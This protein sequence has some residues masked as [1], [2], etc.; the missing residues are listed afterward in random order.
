MNGLNAKGGLVAPE[1]Y[2]IHRERLA[3]HGK[4]I[5][6]AVRGRIER[7]K[8]VLAADYIDTLRGRAA[9]AVKMDIALQD[10]EALVMPTT[11]IVAPKIADVA[12][13]D[14]F[15]AKNALLLR[16]T[17]IVNFFDLCAISLPLPRS[18]GLP[19]G[20]MLVAR[21]GHDQRLF[22]IAA[23]VEKTIA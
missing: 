16:N 9:L 3:A 12:A 5:D 18:G 8:D 13:P 10:F 21:N 4:E 14:S 6:P 1:A 19:A 15:R 2:A 23:A 11:P 17:A 20:L 22:R 7:G